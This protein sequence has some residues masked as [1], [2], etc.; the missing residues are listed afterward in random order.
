MSDVA[1]ITIGTKQ[2]ATNVAVTPTELAQGLGGLAS[3][4]AGTGMLF[5]L[6]GNRSVAVTTAPMLFNL[7]IVFISSDL[8]VVAL[9]QDIAPGYIVNE[10]MLVRY[11]LEVNAGETQ[12]IA[13]SD[14][15][16]IEGY[17]PA[18]VTAFDFGSI[19]E[20]F[21]PVL[22][23]IMIGVVG[24]RIMSALA[25]RMFGK[26]EERGKLPP[27]KPQPIAKE[28]KHGPEAAQPTEVTPQLSEVEVR[29]QTLEGHGREMAKETGLEFIKVEGYESKYPTPL[30]WFT[31]AAGN[32][33]RARDLEELKAKLAM[34]G[35]HHSTPLLGVSFQQPEDI[36]DALKDSIEEELIAYNWYMRRAAYARAHGDEVS[37]QLWIQIANDERDDHYNKFKDRLKILEEEHIPIEER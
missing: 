32:K 4:A 25:K 36:E 2:W 6:G 11:F 14:A 34:I 22:F 29:K 5:D 1:M 9:A 35:K 26:P 19:V 7:D 18:A 28:K 15:V 8:Q 3:L 23:M 16:E 30:Y 31:D 37:A 33:I 17:T 12:G 21:V 10:S 13:A 27:V 24:N 20:V